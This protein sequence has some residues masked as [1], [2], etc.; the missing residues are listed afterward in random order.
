M[1]KELIIKTSEFYR[2]GFPNLQDWL[3]LLRVMKPE[4]KSKFFKNNLV[5]KFIPIRIKRLKEDE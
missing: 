4:E 3:D 1:S 2:K 5:I